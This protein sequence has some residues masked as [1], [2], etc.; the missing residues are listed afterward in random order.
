MSCDFGGLLLESG[1]RKCCR[2]PFTCLGGL[3]VSGVSVCLLVMIFGGCLDLFGDICPLLIFCDKLLVTV[4]R[5]LTV[6]SAVEIP[7]D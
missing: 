3:W 7:R 4:N 2:G 5:I 1:G 6:L